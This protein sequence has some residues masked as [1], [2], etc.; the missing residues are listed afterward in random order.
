METTPQYFAAF[1]HEMRAFA[2]EMRAFE[3]GVNARFDGVDEKLDVMAETLQRHEEKLDE[4]SMMLRV[5]TG[6]HDN[7]EERISHLERSVTRLRLKID[8]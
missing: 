1:A 6:R 8:N 4:H 3:K 7:H 2:N 5:L